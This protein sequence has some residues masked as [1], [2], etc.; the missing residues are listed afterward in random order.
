MCLSTNVPF[1]LL[2][3][4]SPSCLEGP[5]TLERRERGSGG[6]VQRRDKCVLCVNRGLCMRLMLCVSPSKG[7]KYSVLTNK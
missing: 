7:Q 1:F 2:L 4:I 6:G 5:R 3:F